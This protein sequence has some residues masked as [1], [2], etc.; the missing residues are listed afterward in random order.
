MIDRTQLWVWSTV[1][2]IAAAGTDFV[3]GYIARRYG[4]VTKIGR[5]LDPFVDKV[6]ICGAFMCLLVHP[7]SGI[8]V[9]MALTVMGREM[10]VTSLRSFLEQHG[11]DFS[12][13][14][15][16]KVKM[17]LQ[18][19]AVAWS[20]LSLSPEVLAAV[21]AKEFLLLRD[22][23]LWTAVVA[24]IYSGLVYVIRGIQLLQQTD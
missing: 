8:N 17:A 18:C 1:V 12:A 22:L 16:G 2:F 3:D 15:S 5:I 14:W 10:F 7:K 21:P 23:V 20:L 11:K 24:T 19:V 6:I 13:A 9:W 4:L